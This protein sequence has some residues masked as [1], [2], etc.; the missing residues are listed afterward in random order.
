MHVHETYFY[1]SYSELHKDSKM[2]SA[3]ISSTSSACQY[4]PKHLLHVRTCTTTEITETN[5]LVCLKPRTKINNF[6]QA[7]YVQLFCGT[8]KITV[9][10]SY[11]HKLYDP[12][13]LYTFRGY[14][15]ARQEE[16]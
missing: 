2:V 3:L 15:R 8:C 12:H 6:A 7:K 13:F 10:S 11:T 14:L 9:L 4:V 16:S 1:S 5:V